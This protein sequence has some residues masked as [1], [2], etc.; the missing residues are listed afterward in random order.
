[1]WINVF[2]LIFFNPLDLLNLG[3]Y[4]NYLT[5]Y[6]ILRLY[7]PELLSLPYPQ[8]K[9][10]LISV[11]FCAHTTW[12]IHKVRRSVIITPS[13]TQPFLLSAFP[14][15]LFTSS[16]KVHS[17]KFRGS[18][19]EFLGMSHSPLHIQHLTQ[20]ECWQLSL[21]LPAV[22]VYSS[23]APAHTLQNL[24]WLLIRTWPYFRSHL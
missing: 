13:S 10:S 1:M 23:P 2:N 5:F 3:G 18:L 14:W 11:G 17:R 24:C 15:I 19:E 7:L 22:S 8:W 12:I 20:E 6:S 21:S 16:Q 4:Y 9:I